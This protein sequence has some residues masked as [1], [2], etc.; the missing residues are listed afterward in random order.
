MSLEKFCWNH[1]DLLACGVR[2]FVRR[3]SRIAFGTGMAT[4]SSK[5]ERMNAVAS[6]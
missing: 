3:R 1:G 2:A 6:E 4:L 5:S